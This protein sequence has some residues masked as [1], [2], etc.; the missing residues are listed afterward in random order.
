MMKRSILI[1][2]IL[3]LLS[4]CGLFKKSDA[5]DT[6]N[7]DNDNVT[8]ENN[9]NENNTNN[10]NN[11]DEE[12]EAEI[13]EEEEPTFADEIRE[14]EVDTVLLDTEEE[15]VETE[16]LLIEHEQE[17]FYA[18]DIVSELVDF[19]MDFQPDKQYAEVFEGKSDYTYEA[20]HEETEGAV[21]DVNEL[22]LGEEDYYYNPE[23]DDFYFIEY[24]ER[25]YLPERMLERAFYT[26]V[27]FVRKDK[28]VQFG[29]RT[30]AVYLDDVETGGGMS[31]GDFNVTSDSNYST[32]KGDTY[33]ILGV[34]KDTMSDQ[35]LRLNI[36]YQYTK[37]KAMYYNTHDVD[38]EISFI[39]EDDDKDK[40]VIRETV[41]ANDTYE[42]EEDI[43]RTD[44]V[45]IKIIVPTNAMTDRYDA[46]IY[47][48]FY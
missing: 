42:F 27:T 18:Y 28:E 20:E 47:A 32:I 3:I 35:E 11:N 41:K 9:N 13:E 15:K 4:G 5:N 12:N 48:E 19:E 23:D 10:N 17:N 40:E 25:L 2:M 6:N 33:E 16:G 37:I 43:D 36:D 1:A 34:K 31:M 7:V 38:T 46:V 21:L 8:E 29:E 39:I 22:Y 24:N 30:E 26:P 44:V 14:L 45:A